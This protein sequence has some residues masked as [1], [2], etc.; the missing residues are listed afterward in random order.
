MGIVRTWNYAVHLQPDAFQ[1][2]WSERLKKK[3]EILLILGL[4][5][6][7]RMTALLSV[8]KDLGGKGSRYV[9]L[10]RYSPSRSFKSPHKEFID[11][12]LSELDQTM[13]NWGEK[14]NIEIITRAEDNLYVGDSELSKFYVQ[15]DLRPFSD[16]LVD[17][18]SM[19]K[20]LYFT[21][22]LILVK[23]SEKQSQSINLHVIA[24]QDSVLDNQ[25]VES[26]DDTRY[27]KGFT[28]GM[29]RLSIQDTPIIWAPLLARN[30]AVSLSKLRDHIGPTDIYPILPF[31]SRNPRNDDDLLAEYRQ[32]FD[33]EWRLNPMNIMY[34]A[35]DDPL[36]VYQSLL[37]LLHQQEE[38]LKP[39]GGVSMVVSALSSKLS[40]IGAFMAAYDGKTAVAHAI[41]RH[42]PV[43]PINSSFWNTVN[44]VRF[45]QN[46]HSIW[47]TGEP[48]ER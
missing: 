38:A 35:E 39:L 6:D 42:D 13:Q 10:V 14:Q 2:F 22:L 3:R 37:S 33:S 25:I 8:L 5:W 44:L 30:S 18:S 36:D 20:S 19:P 12:N 21:L 9:H 43:K 46:L 45:K 29:T 32:M 27:L 41:G 17:V 28:R 16:I 34:A 23:N 15:F 4:G 48:Y 31:P 24:C 47:L 40:S 26:A 7:P 1:H 11:K